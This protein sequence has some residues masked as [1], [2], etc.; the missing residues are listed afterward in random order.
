MQ[1]KFL[2]QFNE[3]LEITVMCTS[4]NSR[5]SVP[6]SAGQTRAVVLLSE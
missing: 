5:T 3:G 6:C 4:L 1:A 2:I